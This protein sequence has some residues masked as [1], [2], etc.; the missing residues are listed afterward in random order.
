M[1]LS[2]TSIELEVGT[3]K[4]KV[5][6][7]GKQKQST[8]NQ[9]VSLGHEKESKGNWKEINRNQK[10]KKNQQEIKRLDGPNALGCAINSERTNILLPV[11]AHCPL[12]HLFFLDT[13]GENHYP[14]KESTGHQ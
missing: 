5:D 2:N 4:G 8:G 3:W 9:K 13:V 11:G 7:E 10:I 14:Q 12:C 1:Y 6:S